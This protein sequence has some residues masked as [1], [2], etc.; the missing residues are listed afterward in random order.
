MKS[1]R[2]YRS[3]PSRFRRPTL[4][5]VGCGDV[6]GRIGRMLAGHGQQRL[7]V[8]G[9]ARSEDQ[10][11][12]LRALGIVPLR[13]D[14]D[15]R[16]RLAR[17]RALARWMVDLAPPPERGADDP[18]SARLVAALRA[19]ARRSMQAW[20][21]RLADATTA[22]RRVPEASPRRWVYISTTGVYGDCGG[23]WFDETRAV[24]PAS[25]RA[26]RRVDAER[27][28]RA[29][30]RAGAARASILRVPGIYGH[31]RLPL[32]RL[33]RGLPAL[34]EA[35]DVYTNHVHADDLARIA[36]KAVFRGRPGRVVHAV[37]DSDLRMGDYFDR[38]ADAFGLPRPP[39]LS[40]AELAAKVSPVMLSFMSESRRLRN[41]RLK[42]E[43]RVRLRWP[44]V[45]A[46]LAD[47]AAQR[48][49][50]GRESV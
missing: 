32:E 10:A 7:R 35:D 44:D 36:W 26:Q 9:T 30:A 39:R 47:A 5:L 3:L 1:A 45:D 17:L 15:D 2:H 34:L 29:A 41:Q 8:L 42:R 48:S 6:G 37:D 16:R 4:L 14:L 31:D 20:R 23:A 49:K 12:R 18:R 46:T 50:P 27:R 28:F 11:A 24:R 43:L 38:V 13:A 22:L 33:Q 21:G 25:D 40:R 19:P